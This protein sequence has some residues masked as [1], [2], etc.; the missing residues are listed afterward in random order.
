MFDST[1]TKLSD[2]ELKTEEMLTL[3]AFREYLP[4]MLRDV[5][6]EQEYNTSTNL[7][8]R[9]LQ[10]PLLNKQLAFTLIEILLVKVFPELSL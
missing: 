1:S 4:S 2:E 10:H 9:S 6:G 3:S 8:F 5:M 7:L